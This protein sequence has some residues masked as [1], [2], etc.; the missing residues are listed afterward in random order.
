MNRRTYK[1]AAAAIGAVLA[2]T[3]LASTGA[4]AGTPTEPSPIVVA[5]GASTTDAP[6]NT[7][8]AIEAAA[9]RGATIAEA[10]LRFAKNDPGPSAMFGHDDD[11]AAKTTCTGS[12][13]TNW[14]GTLRACSAADYAPWNTDPRFAGNKPDGTPKVPI[15]YIYDALA[16]VHRLGLKLLLDVKTPPTQGQM[17]NLISYVDRPEFNLAGQPAMRTRIIWMANTT[18]GL[19]AVRAWYPG[20]KY[21]LLENAGTDTIRTCSSLTSLGA[22][23]YAVQNYR[24]DGPKAAYWHTCATGFETVTWTTNSAAYEV[25]AEWT[26]LGEAGLDYIITN[27]PDVVNNLLNPAPAST[28][29]KPKKERIPVLQLPESSG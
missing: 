4:E 15:M 12:I 3:A 26:R 14:F 1:L 13:S 28:Q 17:D 21:W 9:A 23:G 6:E 19:T 24:V 22:V 20:L 11:L 7:V 18:A 2:A 29:A 25:P 27:Q 10:D 5:H 16:T 8:P